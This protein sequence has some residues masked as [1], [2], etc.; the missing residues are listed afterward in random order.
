MP[1][2]ARLKV[3]PL[4]V[5]RHCSTKATVAIHMELASHNE[6]TTRVAVIVGAVKGSLLQKFREGRKFLRCCTNDVR[7]PVAFITV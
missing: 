3:L 4:T 7:T 5:V 2:V 6:R 1:L